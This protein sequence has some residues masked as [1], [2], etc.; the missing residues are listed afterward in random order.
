MS[1]EPDPR[2]FKP[3]KP[4]FYCCHVKH[5]HSDYMRHELVIGINLE[6]EDVQ[7]LVNQHLALHGLGELYKCVFV[8]EIDEHGNDVP[9]TKH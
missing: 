2:Q 9:Q 7:R 1:I 5:N 4:Q 8:H 3:P 6:I